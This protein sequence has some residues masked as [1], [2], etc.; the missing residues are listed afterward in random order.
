MKDQV[1]LNQIQEDE[2]ARQW[3]AQEDAFVVK[4]AKKKAEIRVKEGRAKPIDWLT[5]MLRVID[6]TRN[7]LDEEITDSELELVDPDGVF[8]GLSQS[9]LSELQKDIDTFL[10][11]ET[12]AQNR[13][14]WKVLIDNGSPDGLFSAESFQQTMLIICQ[15]RQKTIAPKGRALNPVVADINKLLSPKTYEE[16]EGLEVQVKKKL[17]SDEPIDYDYWE[18]L[19]RSLA[20]WKARAKLKKVYQAVIEERVRGLRKQQ[21]EEAESV[22][23]KLAPLAPVVQTILADDQLTDP[24]DFEGLDPEPLLQI[25]PEDKSLQI[26]D[27]TA[28][29]NQAVIITLLPLFNSTGPLF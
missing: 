4:Q 11:L 6:P 28:F 5:V 13:E 21:C 3:V 22:R 20:V 18:E 2:Q 9:Q 16:L 1:R 8:E 10:S 29:L 26:M 12:N 25:R 19:L 7:P 17:N 15:D 27:E 23:Q 24:K 14:F